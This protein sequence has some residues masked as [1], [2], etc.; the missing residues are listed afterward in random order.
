MSPILNYD[1]AS[2]IIFGVV[3]ILLIVGLVL[4][5]EKWRKRK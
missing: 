2:I 1:N 4:D 5:I 3:I